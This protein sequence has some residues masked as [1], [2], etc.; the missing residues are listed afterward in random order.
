[1]DVILID[2]LLRDVGI[3][4]PVAREQARAILE[5]HGLTTPRKLN[6]ATGKI[7]AA[8]ALLADHA[9]LLCGDPGCA[10]LAVSRAAGREMIGVE[11]AHC[12]IC[13]GS[14]QR[15]AALL[16]ARDM[17]AVRR[18][19]LLLVGGTPQQHHEL[20]QALA[21]G[22]VELR[23]I[24][25]LKRAHSAAEAARQSAWADVVA[26]WAATPV[27]HKVSQVYTDAV[28]PHAL[29]VIVARRGIES[30]CA[31]IRAAL[32]GNGHRVG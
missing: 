29:R 30:L 4:D 18:S 2:D 16:L 11:P 21:A 20:D 15:R 22:G 23:A 6:M 7:L 27:K 19:R 8:R 5:R 13:A 28:T 17:L 3:A 31:D 26:I 24:D 10:A 9:M 1:M 25:G 32:V 14:G 12:I